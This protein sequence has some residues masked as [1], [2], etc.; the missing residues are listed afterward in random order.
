MGLNSGYEVVR[1]QILSMDPLPNVNKA[2]YIVQQVEKQ[3]Q[4]SEIMNAS[5]VVEGGVPML[6][7]DNHLSFLTLEEEEGRSI[8]RTSKI[9]S[10][11]TIR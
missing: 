2:Y 10:V 5:S 11:T 1:N 6:F 7:K 9:G 4:M 3:K 8:E